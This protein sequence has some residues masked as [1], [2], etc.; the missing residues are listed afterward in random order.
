MSSRTQTDRRCLALLTAFLAIAV[1]EVAASDRI[2]VI[3]DERAGVHLSDQHLGPGSRLLV[4]AASPDTRSTHSV[5]P[6]VPHPLARH[7]ALEAIVH[8]AARV[9]ALDP[10]LVHAVIAT[11]SAYAARAVSHRGAQGL[12]QLMPATARSYGVTDAFDLHQNVR[13]G[14]LHLRRLLDQFGQNTALA[15]AAYNAGAGAVARYGGNAPPF[16]ETTAYVQRVL[17]RYAALRRLA[18]NHNLAPQNS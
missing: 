3:E 6:R 14:A 4:G 17:Q 5:P 13:A 12:M 7:A 8:Q 11:E 15:L 10:E 9:N 1:T 18:P 16:A 2:F